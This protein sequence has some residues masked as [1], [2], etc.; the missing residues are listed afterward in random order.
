VSFWVGTE[1]TSTDGI[2]IV[3]L[4]EVAWAFGPV[5]ASAVLVGDLIIVVSDLDHVSVSLM[6]VFMGDLGKVLSI[7]LKEAIFNFINVIKLEWAFC[8][9]STIVLYALSGMPLIRTF[10]LFFFFLFIFHFC[11]LWYWHLLICWVKL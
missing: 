11:L 2:D 7:F 6:V 8:P 3:L 5:D 10:L 1:V 9:A 4:S